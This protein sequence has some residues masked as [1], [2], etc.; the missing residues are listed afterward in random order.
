MFVD[1]FHKKMCLF[2]LEMFERVNACMQTVSNSLRQIFLL[3]LKL[4]PF[5]DPSI[6]SF[7]FIYSTVAPILSALSEIKQP[8]C[9]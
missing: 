6:Y 1:L 2:N 4:Y 3:T 8:K 5:I 9:R 7:S